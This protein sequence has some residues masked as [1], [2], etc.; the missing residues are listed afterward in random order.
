MLRAKPDLTAGEAA[1]GAAGWTAG[2]WPGRRAEAGMDERIRTALWRNQLIDMTTTGRRSGQP[3]R[4][5]IALHAIDGRLFISGQPA[6]RKRA[7]IANLEADP[8]LTIHLKGAVKV[9]LPATAR[10]ITDEVE[11]RAIL[12]SIAAGW[13]RD[14]EPMVRASP[15]IEVAV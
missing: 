11:R 10:I 13:R 2:G 6:P 4:I 1:G 5:E 12:A 14:P 15:L 7:W 8:R 3:R 9:D